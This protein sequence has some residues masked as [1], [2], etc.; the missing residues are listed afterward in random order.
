MK[1]PKVDLRI[2]QLFKMVNRPLYEAVEWDYIDFFFW[3]AERL[4]GRDGGSYYCTKW[5]TFGISVPLLWCT[6][7]QPNQI[8]SLVY[9]LLWCIP[10]PASRDQRRGQPVLGIIGV[11]FK[12]VLVHDPSLCDMFLDGLKLLHF[13]NLCWQLRV[14]FRTNLSWDFFKFWPCQVEPE[15]RA[16]VLGRAQLDIFFRSPRIC[17]CVEVDRPL[18]GIATPKLGTFGRGLL[19]RFWTCNRLEGNHLLWWC[20]VLNGLGPGHGPNYPNQTS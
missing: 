16:W 12:H 2:V 15:K 8:P 10:S 13:P 3:C 11:V 18:H 4:L 20:T 14:T 19:W 5:V 7:L 17:L 6:D 9:R 1:G